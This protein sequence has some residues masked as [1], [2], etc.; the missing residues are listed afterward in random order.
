[1]STIIKHPFVI[2]L[3]CGHFLPHSASNSIIFFYFIFF[4]YLLLN[5]H[6]FVIGSAGIG[7]ML[8]RRKR[9]LHFKIG[10]RI[11]GQRQINARAT[12]KKDEI[13]STFWWRAIYH[14]S[15]TVGTLLTSR[16]MAVTRKLKPSTLTFKY[17]ITQLKFS[18]TYTIYFIVHASTW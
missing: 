4:I 5:F 18:P 2:Y 3:S 11:R 8:L 16:F 13:K 7:I 15:H 12:T 9:M 1:M 10:T 6:S 17:A 14:C